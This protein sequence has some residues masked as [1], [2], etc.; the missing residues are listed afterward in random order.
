MKGG[1][2][3]GIV[4][5]SGGYAADILPLLLTYVTGRRVGPT[6][7]KESAEGLASYCVQRN[8]CRTVLLGRVFR[9][10]TR[11]YDI[12]AV[13]VCCCRVLIGRGG[14]WTDPP[15]APQALKFKNFFQRES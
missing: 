1:A 9:Q 12:G 14:V 15:A 3:R 4:A 11:R 13:G 6:R 8:L 2:D 7:G 10:Y 5:G